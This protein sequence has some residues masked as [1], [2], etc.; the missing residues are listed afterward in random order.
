MLNL[1]S[2]WTVAKLLLIRAIVCLQ[3]LT[4]ENKFSLM[5]LVERSRSKSL[6][7]LLVQLHISQSL[8]TPENLSSLEFTATTVLQ[9]D[10]PITIHNQGKWNSELGTVLYDDFRLTLFDWY[11]LTETAMLQYPYDQPWGCEEG[12]FKE[13]CLQLMPG[14]PIERR[15]CFSDSPFDY[16]LFVA[17]KRKG[18]DFKLT[19]KL[20]ELR[21]TETSLDELFKNGETQISRHEYETWNSIAVASGDELGLTFIDT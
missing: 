1:L 19:L 16:P 17:K 8:C 3:S 4:R 21:W 15:H 9:H 20:Q 6:P 11:D 18:H 7:K 12:I 13:H 2:R 5:T 10:R 14:Q